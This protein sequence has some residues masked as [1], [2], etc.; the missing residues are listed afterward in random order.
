MYHGRIVATGT[1]EQ[2]LANSPL[3]AQLA[4]P[5]F[6]AFEAEPAADPAKV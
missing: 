2:L 1:H 4:Q 5:Q 3:Y 6:G